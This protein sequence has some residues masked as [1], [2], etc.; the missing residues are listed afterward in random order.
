MGFAQR[1]AQVRDSIQEDYLNQEVKKEM[2]ASLERVIKRA[3]VLGEDFSKAVK[4]SIIQE[5]REEVPA[6]F[7]SLET[8]GQ[9]IQRY[10]CT[11]TRIVMRQFV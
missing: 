1:L 11:L 5:I 4:A 9:K 6:L 2:L 3:Q 8:I 7:K 10:L